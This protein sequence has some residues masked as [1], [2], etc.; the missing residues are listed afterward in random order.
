MKN[1]ESVLQ[2]KNGVAVIKA[3]DLAVL[4][5]RKHLSVLRAIDAIPLEYLRDDMFLMI[6]S[7]VFLTYGGVRM[8][9]VPRR[10]LYVC[11][12]IRTALL[13][14][15]AEYREARRDEFHA[16]MPPK[17]I[18]KFLVRIGDFGFHK[19]ALRMFKVVCW[20]KKYDPAKTVNIPKAS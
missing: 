6:D 4:L 15:D 10:H 17:L 2:I 12:R 14:F 9:D 1:I 20:F 16:A 13:I 8:I 5:G 3:E 18:I 7:E 19:L 11:Q